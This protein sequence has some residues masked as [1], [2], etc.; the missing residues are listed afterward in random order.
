MISVR[1][2]ERGQSTLV[3]ALVLPVLL[4]FVG[5]GVDLGQLRYQQRKLQVVADAAALAGAGEIAAGS[6][7]NVNY[8]ASLAIA[9]NNFVAGV[10]GNQNP[11]IN[12]PPQS[13]P[14]AGN[15]KFVE[16]IISQNAPTYFMRILGVTSA[17]ISAR[18]VGGLGSGTSC[19][20]ALAP[21][22]TAFS[23]SGGAVVNAGC[24]I[25]DN[26][27]GSQAFV[28]TGGS[29]VSTT[30]INVVG[31]YAMQPSSCNPPQT[32]PSIGAPAV[33]DP[34]AYVPAPSVGA[35]DY[36][37]GYTA[38]GGTPTISPGVYCGGITV[39]AHAL[40][41]LN[42]GTYILNGGGLSVQGNSDV[43]GTGVTF[44]DTCTT[45]CVGGYQP[46]K[47][48]GGSNTSLIAPTS[49]SLA[50]IL[51][52]QDRSTN[53]SAKNGIAGN[54]TTVFQGALYFP[55]TELDYTGGSTNTAYTIIVA[56][57]LMFAGN[58][59]MNSD[60]SSLSGGSPIKRAALME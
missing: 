3:V 36:P 6:S 31:N 48:T 39:T 15:S 35:C 44:Y 10:N 21:T 8:S 56:N 51:F 49:G 43:Q 19:I 17:T 30:Q 28:E 29:C 33:S 47:L 38:N 34:L 41:K 54:G 22:G 16:V 18:A 27:N 32:T 24:G 46:I 14:H 53:S 11:A 26:S 12:L 9:N 25:Y 5:L 50:G 20:Y 59:S 13:G 55:T 7:S 52:F 45:G 2:D 40:L 23:A 42:P 37:N 58:S 4:G 1:S 57:N 60:Y